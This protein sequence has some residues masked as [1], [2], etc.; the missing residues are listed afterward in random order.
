MTD[1]PDTLSRRMLMRG[2]MGAV[3]IA[4]AAPALAQRDRKVAM[5]DDPKAMVATLTDGIFINSNEN[6]LGPAP[7]ALQALS[8][9]DPLAGRY[10]MAFASKLES[11]FARQNGLSPDQVQVHPGSFMPL[12]SVALSYSSKSR[13]IAYFEP[14][15]DQG[16][17]G[18]GNQPVTRLSLI[19][20]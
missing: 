8:G 19:H 4:G 1:R 13:P 5:S 11:L 6:P 12:R 20:I 3:A 15:F 10:G 2:A 14:T 7:A 18:K 17:L 9:L 16:F